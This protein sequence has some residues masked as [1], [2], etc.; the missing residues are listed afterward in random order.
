MVGIVV[1]GAL[2]SLGW[3]LIRFGGRLMSPFASPTM[4][5][6]LM[7]DRA[8][9]ISIGSAV[10]YRGVTIGRVES[11]SRAPDK[12]HVYIDT[13]VDKD[14]PLPSNLR[15][16]I[17]AQGIVGAG[18]TIFLELDGT[19]PQGTLTREQVVQTRFVGLELL[20]DEF[21]ALATELRQTIR[22]FREAN[23]V[24]H[25]DEQVLKVGKLLDSAQLVIGD[26]QLKEDLRASLTNLRTTTERAERIAT[27]F[28]R[29]SGDLP[30][31]SSEATGALSEF[32]ATV[33][34]TQTGVESA[35]KQLNEV[36]ARVQS[37]AEKVN[38][39]QGTAGALVNDPRLYE[40]L[41]D[42][43]RE[44]NATVSTL[45]RLLEQWEKEG[46]PLKLN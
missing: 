1:L 9:G 40:S 5:V 8:D 19:E 13:Q 4:G 10:L 24:A 44:L 3:M 18:A 35:S 11:V 23:I 43:A 39:G 26:P 28:E 32:R 30:K 37:V 7:A 42:S 21:T 34:T 27:S 2:I 17:R 25:I 16:L 15:G 14:P 12:I 20:P 29:F 41:V 31:L 38:A 6:R 22:Q 36:L 46:L 45:R 33:K